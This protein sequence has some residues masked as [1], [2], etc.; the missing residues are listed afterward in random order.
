[1]REVDRFLH[2]EDSP[3]MNGA[4]LHGETIPASSPRFLIYTLREPV[5]VVGAITPWTR[6]CSWPRGFKLG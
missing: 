6:P 2:D 1:V 4:L 5:G 3:G